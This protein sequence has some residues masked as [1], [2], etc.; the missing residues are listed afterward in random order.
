MLSQPLPGWRVPNSP[1]LYKTRGGSDPKLGV[2]VQDQVGDAGEASL[3]DGITKADC[4]FVDD[5]IWICLIICH[6]KSLLRA[7]SGL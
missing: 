6:Y 1:S 5:G 3:E 2:V 7:I 4:D